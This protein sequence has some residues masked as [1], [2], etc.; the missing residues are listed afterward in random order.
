LAN[1]ANEKN[2]IVS[3]TIENIIAKEVIKPENN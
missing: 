2:T 3:K 1:M